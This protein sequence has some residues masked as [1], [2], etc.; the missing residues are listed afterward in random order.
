MNPSTPPSTSSSKKPAAAVLDKNS[1]LADASKRAAIMSFASTSSTSPSNADTDTRPSLTSQFNAMTTKRGKR[2]F[3][4]ACEGPAN[5][6]NL[7]CEHQFTPVGALTV[8]PDPKIDPKI[9]KIVMDKSE[10]GGYRVTEEYAIR[11]LQKNNYLIVPAIKDIKVDIDAREYALHF[12]GRINIP[13][14]RAT[15]KA[16]TCHHDCNHSANIECKLAQYPK[17]RDG[18]IS[19]LEREDQNLADALKLGWS[20]FYGR[21]ILMARYKTKEQREAAFK[22]YCDEARWREER[23]L[24]WEEC[25]LSL[26]ADELEVCM[27]RWEDGKR[28]YLS[29]VDGDAADALGRVHPGNESATNDPSPA[30]QGETSAQGATRSPHPQPLFPADLIHRGECTASCSA[31]TPPRSKV[32]HHPSAGFG[33]IIDKT[34]TP[35]TR[36]VLE[37]IPEASAEETL[38]DDDEMPKSKINN[39]SA[40][41]KWHHRSEE[42]M[43]FHKQ[44]EA[45]TAR[46][47]KLMDSVALDD[48][49]ISILRAQANAL[50]HENKELLAINHDLKFRAAQKL[51]DEIDDPPEPQTIFNLVTKIADWDLTFSCALDEDELPVLYSFQLMELLDKLC[52]NIYLVSV[53]TISEQTRPAI[54]KAWEAISFGGRS[55]HNAMT[56]AIVLDRGLMEEALGDKLAKTVELAMVLDETFRNLDI[57][58]PVLNRKAKRNRVEDKKL[59]SMLKQCLEL[60]MKICAYP[61]DLSWGSINKLRRDVGTQPLQKQMEMKYMG[62]ASSDPPTET[63]NKKNATLYIQVVTAARKIDDL[64]KANAQDPLT[65]YKDMLKV[66]YVDKIHPVSNLP[67]WKTLIKDEETHNMIAML[68][69][70]AADEEEGRFDQVIQIFRECIHEDL[71]ALHKFVKSNP[72]NFMDKTNH[73]FLTDVIGDPGMMKFDDLTDQQVWGWILGFQIAKCRLDGDVE[74]VLGWAVNFEGQ[75]DVKT[76]VE[77]VEKGVR[78]PDVE[79]KPMRAGPSTTHRPI[80]TPRRVQQSLHKTLSKEVIK[81]K[82]GKDESLEDAVER[83]TKDVA[84]MGLG[85]VNPNRS[86]NDGDS[87]PAAPSFTPHGRVEF[88]DGNKIPVFSAKLTPEQFATI[89]ASLEAESSSPRVDYTAL[90]TDEDMDRQMGE[91]REVFSSY[92][93]KAE[94]DRAIEAALNDGA[95]A[96]TKKEGQ[97]TGGAES[98][99]SS[100]SAKAKGKQPAKN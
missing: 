30:T 61:K 92:V 71:L 80:S 97:T 67:G 12:T 5:C 74:E 75:K 48:V 93:G 19:A 57:E 13:F 96:A 87:A 91:V 50:L 22:V 94:L 58:L 70:I 73:K 76:K 40:D 1:P 46:Y 31:S 59:Q 98:G 4:K 62:L 54:K 6:K 86:R 56:S 39:E 25:R 55:F 53:Q 9:V 49:D 65:K 79:V 26:S 20:S 95:K 99:S 28:P 60:S 11:M 37:P 8:A 27:E 90:P 78:D 14:E 32:Y 34:P 45:D 44:Q 100:V 3:P 51:L 52:K 42:S 66:F 35:S 83:T 29:Y 7:L 88:V 72:N 38:E 84:T 16:Y 64:L 15:L 2:F 68:M 21:V 23:A 89:S 85:A 47:N 81:S 17:C 63:M 10:E 69:M 33:E 18:F 82:V 41:G 24:F 36:A 77:T 43:R